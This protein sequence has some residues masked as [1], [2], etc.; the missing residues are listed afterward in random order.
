[1]S[2]GIELNYSHDE[3]EKELSINLEDTG[4]FEAEIKAAGFLKD[5]N[6]EFLLSKTNRKQIRWNF[7]VVNHEE[8]NGKRISDTTRG[9]A[10]PGLNE[11]D[12][13]AAKVK[14]ME[15]M[16]TRPAV[17]TGKGW[18]GVF[19]PEDFIGCGLI[20]VVK[21]DTYEGVTRPKVNGYRKIK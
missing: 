2:E 17:A 3:L 20:I 21:E 9:P 15:G 19:D 7:A 18:D 14:M 12:D 4:I 1:M 8:L 5:D 6:G 10:V 13:D 16:L 11:E